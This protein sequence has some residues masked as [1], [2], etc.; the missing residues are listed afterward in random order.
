MYELRFSTEVIRPSRPLQLTRVN[1][2]GAKMC[3]YIVAVRYYVL[4]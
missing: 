1:M 2:E 3:M 4:F